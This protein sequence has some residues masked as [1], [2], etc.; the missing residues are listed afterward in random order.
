MV[1]MLKKIEW[2]LQSNTI[3]NLAAQFKKWVAPAIRARY[4][5]EYFDQNLGWMEGRYHILLQVFRLC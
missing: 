2:L 3:G 4:Q 5:R 1:T